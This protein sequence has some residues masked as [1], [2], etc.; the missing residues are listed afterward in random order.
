MNDAQFLGLMLEN[1]M[2]DGEQKSMEEIE[3]YCSGVYGR[4]KAKSLVLELIATGFLVLTSD[5]RVM[6][7]VKHEQIV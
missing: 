5:L 2:K 7:A 3:A 6:K 4:M 1:S